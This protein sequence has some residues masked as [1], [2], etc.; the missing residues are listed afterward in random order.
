M[1]KLNEAIVVL[2]RAI[3]IKPQDARAWEYKGVII[4]SLG[5]WVESIKYFDRAIE[6]ESKQR[7]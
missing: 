5:N 7:I 1:N 2:D 3:E 6:L 4:F